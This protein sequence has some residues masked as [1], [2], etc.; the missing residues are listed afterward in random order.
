MA[1][2]ASRRFGRKPHNCHKGRSGVTVRIA[3]HGAS[4]SPRRS[5]SRIRSIDG[6]AP[7]STAISLT[8]TA[9]IGAAW[10]RHRAQR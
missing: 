10:T 6:A 5:L 9:A 7:S 3:R 4:L 2:E 1:V 8:G